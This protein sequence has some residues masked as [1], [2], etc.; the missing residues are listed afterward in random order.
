MLVP[1]AAAFLLGAPSHAI[2]QIRAEVIVRGFDSPVAVVADPVDPSVLFVV[3]QRG[4]IRVVRDDKILDEPLLDLRN[5]I[6]SGGERGLLGLAFAPDA[7]ERECE[8]CDPNRFF[9]NFTN[10]QGDTVI[11]RFRRRTDNPLTAAPESRFDLLWP[12]GRRTIDQPFANH[13][14]GHLA[15]GPDGYLYIGMGDGGSS[16]DPLNH[17][18]NPRTLLGKMLRIDVAVADDD[19]VGYRVP[20]DNPFVDQDPINALPEIW[21][22]GLR[23]PW[24]YSFDDPIAGTGALLIGDVGQNAREEINFEPRGAGGRNYGWRLREG[25]QGYD[26]RTTAAFLPLRD[27][28]HDYGRAIG[29]S[30]TGGLI[31]RG[32]KLDPQFNGRYF[33]ADF[34][35]GRVFS[36]GLHLDD[37]GDATADDERE[38]TSAL[39]GRNLLGMISSFGTDSSGEVLI[40]NYAAGTIV[41]IVPDEQMVP[42]PP[43]A[44]AERDGD[45]VRVTWTPPL[46]GVSAIRY[47]IEITRLNKTVA[48]HDV[49]RGNDATITAPTGSCIRVRAV[50]REGAGPPSASICP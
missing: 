41:K 47:S 26:A 28:I 13:N 19:A 17:A 2:G 38:H 40:V 32:S 33:F 50:G 3:E 21:A 39:G 29:Q 31:Y 35:S 5:Q 16:G 6:S 25:R 9:V 49:G 43:H 44:Q 23:N 4:L 27:P 46:S 1:I 7:P 10:R 12:D 22:F 15:F 14:G 11:A 24:R 36:L 34:V 42:L 20:E 37:A 45:Q 8:P 18:Q 30:V 48:Q